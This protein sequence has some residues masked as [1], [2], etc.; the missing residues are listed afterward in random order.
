[1]NPSLTLSAIARQMMPDRPAIF[2]EE[3]SLSYGAFEIARFERPTGSSRR[4]PRTTT[5][6]L[7]QLLQNDR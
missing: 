5:A 1:M 4:C 7:R 6:E 3:G 2:W